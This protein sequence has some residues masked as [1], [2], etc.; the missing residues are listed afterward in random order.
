M[1][2]LLKIFVCLI[3]V[4]SLSAC[5]E[6]NEKTSNKNEV[7]RWE[8][9]G[10]ITYESIEETKVLEVGKD[11]DTGNYIMKY[12]YDET[13]KSMQFNRQYFIFISNLKLDDINGENVNKLEGNVINEYHFYPEQSSDT[14][15]NI[16]LNDGNYLYI[17]H[18]AIEKALDGTITIEKE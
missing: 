8:C 10:D 1:K 2:K 13:G 14:S 9:T 4:L 12:E 5:S 17:Y 11:I 18:P 6:E 15:I 7:F 16:S 3:V